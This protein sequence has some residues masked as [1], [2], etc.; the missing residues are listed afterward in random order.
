MQKVLLLFALFSS[1]TVSIA[2]KLSDI[3]M[4]KEPLVLKA[5]G[6]FFVDGE[7]E[8]QSR[9]E[10]G[11]FFPEGHLTVNQMYVNFMIPQK[12]KGSTSFVLIHGM[13]LSGKTYETT[14]DG[15]MG[16]NEYLVRK[17]YPVYVVDQVGIARSGFNQKSYN[18]VRNKEIEPAEQPAI[19]RTSDEST[20]VNFRFT[21]TDHTPVPEAKFPMNALNEFSKQSIPFMA[22]TVPNPNPNF[23]N[24][25]LLAANLKKTVLISHS[26]SGA[27]PLEAALL[28]PE[29]I[30]A[31]VMVE[32]GGTGAGYTDEQIKSLS[33]IPVLIVYGDNLEIETGVPNHSWKA[34][35]DGWNNFVG[36]LK[37]AGGTARMMFLPALG[38]RGNSHMLM[39]DTNNQQIADLILEWLATLK[40]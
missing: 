34:S 17:G 35:F 3:V 1:A 29:G 10:M 4:E 32:P 23:K 16:W 20:L 5:V 19:I 21:T 33:K 7:P 28:N 31:I 22:G 38:I 24:L 12:R 39:M 37:T 15:R 13:T 14:P 9:S 30:K 27:F 11:G 8:Q 40:K 6:S 18:R 25:S 36:R 26:Q 2:Q